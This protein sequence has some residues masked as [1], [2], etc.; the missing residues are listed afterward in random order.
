MRTIRIVEH[1]SLDG[2]IQHENDENFVH[3]AWTTPYR[4]SAGLG[5]DQSIRQ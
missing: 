2:V 1:I 4:T 3:G 5:A